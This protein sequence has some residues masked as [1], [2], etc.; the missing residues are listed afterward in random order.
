MDVRELALASALL[1][2][3]CATEPTVVKVPVVERAVPPAE[4][5]A[6]IQPPG[7][8][9][10]APASSSVACVDPAGRDALVSYVDMLRQRLDAWNA[11][12]AP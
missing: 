5:A 4:L 2:A 12:A 1:V 3:G 9:F 11:W 10:T 6:P 7:P 8:I